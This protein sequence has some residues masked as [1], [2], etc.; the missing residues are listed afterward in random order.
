MRRNWSSNRILFLV[1][2]LFLC[3]VFIMLSF[4]GILSPAEGIL[5]TP[6]NV[7][8]R[9]FT[10][11]LQS[12]DRYL[13]RF[14]ENEVLLERIAVLEEALA[15]Q[16]AELIDLREIASDYE[17][18]TDLVDYTSASDDQ[19]FVLADVIGQGQYGF[20]RSIIINKGTRNGIA[21]GMPVVTD[22]GLVGRVF[23]VTANFSQVQLVTD[24]N[25]FVSGRLQDTRA[26]GTVQGA[27]LSTGSLTMLHIPPSTDVQQ[28]NLVFTSGLGGNFPPDLFIGTVVSVRN[29]EF[30]L[31]QEATIQSQI[32]FATLESVLVITDFEPADLS[33]F[34]AAEDDS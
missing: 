22:L 16:Q 18:I 8:T 33:I 9:F 23:D 30:E 27:G 4:F 25:S 12:A 11:S 10:G 21:V 32:D 3:V 17:R 14:E 34:E 6:V 20:V 15:R 13:T 19:E 31:S 5:A 24:Q 1:V 29:L 2:T 28:G 26:D 7:T